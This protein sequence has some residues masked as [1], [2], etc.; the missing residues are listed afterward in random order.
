MGYRLFTHESLAHFSPYNYL[1]GRQ[2]LLCQT[3]S[4][5]LHELPELDLDVKTAW[6]ADVTA[7][8]EAFKRGLSIA[9]R[10]LA[11][12]HAKD[13]LRYAYTWEKSNMPKPKQYQ[14]KD[15]VYVKVHCRFFR[16]TGE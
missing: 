14:V 5:W 16:N 2:P 7:R 12:A 8:A 9:M 13:R 15:F 11:V 10:N 3:V 6:V 1:F 4:N